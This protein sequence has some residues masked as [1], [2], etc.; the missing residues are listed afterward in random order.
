MILS[1][2]ILGEIRALE[3][4][5][6]LTA[7]QLLERA[8]DPKSPLHDYFDWDDQ[9]AAHKHRMLEAERLIIRV[10]VKVTAKPAEPTR[11]QVR[12]TTPPPPPPAKKR[13]AAA[14]ERLRQLEVLGEFRAFEPA[15]RVE[16]KHDEIDQRKR[17]AAAAQ[18][19]EERMK[20]QVDRQL[21]KEGVLATLTT[22]PP[23][24]AARATLDEAL[25]ALSAWRATYGHLPLLRGLCCE[26]DRLKGV[27][28]FESAVY[29]AQRLEDKGV[30][31]AR[32]AELAADEYSVSRHEVLQRLR[33]KLG[34][35]FAP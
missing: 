27:A 4:S 32:A 14:L 28:R 2:E 34:S 7:R 5:G 33:S 10:R 11:A 21:R 31:R 23:A 19:A 13:D 35:T 25:A 29:R 8:K 1:P 9:R 26:L 16:S 30:D 3:Q 15:D 22:P 24:P 18:R 6:R 12:I 20:E 17:A